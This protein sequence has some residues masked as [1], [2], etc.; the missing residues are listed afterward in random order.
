MIF[1]FLSCVLPLALAYGPDGANGSIEAG[2]AEGPQGLDE[3]LHDLDAGNARVAAEALEEL[4]EVGGPAVRRALEELMDDQAEP[5][6][7]RRWRARLVAR[8]GEGENV[9]AALK[10]LDD[11]DPAVRRELVAFLSRPGLEEQLGERIAALARLAV[12]DPSL[13]VRTRAIGGLAELDEVSSHRALNGLL[14]HLPGPERL[15]AARGLAGAWRARPFVLER[16]RA[17]FTP[18]DDGGNDGAGQRTPDDVLAVLLPAYGRLLAEQ[19]SGGETAADRV[20]LVLGLRHPDPTVRV[21]AGL[22]FDQLIRRLRSLADLDRARRILGAMDAE[23]FDRRV[24]LYEQC[25]M[26]LRGRPDTARARHTAIE[27]G[28]LCGDSGT[29]EERDWRVSANYLEALSLFAAGDCESAA[30][31]LARAGRLLDGLLA[32]RPDERRPELVPK[33]DD[34][35]HLSARVAL[36]QAVTLEAARAVVTD[37]ETAAPLAPALELLRNA[38]ELELQAQLFAQENGLA[39]LN[40]LDLLLDDDLSPLTVLLS[41]PGL[42]AWT[43]EER[44][45]ICTLV[46]RGIRSVAPE[47]MPGFEPFDDPDARAPELLDLSRQTLLAEFKKARVGELQSELAK[48]WEATLDVDGQELGGEQRNRL[49]MVGRRLQI[50]REQELS[51]F[52]FPST[53]ALRLSALM[54]DE[55]A[56]P[57]EARE[58]VLRMRADLDRTGHLQSSYQGLELAAQIDISVGASYMDEGAPR[59]AEVE[60]EKAV[61]RLEEYEQLAIERG[62]PASI[63]GRIRLRRSTALVSLAVNANV[64][65]RD[66][67]RALGFFERAYALRQDDFMKVLLACYRARSNEDEAARRILRDVPPA[68]DLYYNLACTYALLGESAKAILY[69]QREFEENHVGDASLAKQQQWARQDPDLESLRDDARFVA[70]T[71]G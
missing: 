29:P 52:R 26:S 64:K 1:R 59:R 53:L 42:Q 56:R 18:L 37:V 47:E 21:A 10:E 24:L 46:A 33:V 5:T 35:L 12:E 2:G 51:E 66:P 34:W 49:L 25:L 22:G 71:G 62:F 6:L 69:L 3:R 48:L 4:A 65:L 9:P 31:P 50:T 8:A 70:I 67:E 40:D 54:R 58:L 20:P 30:L 38:H 68:P 16:V 39:V 36:F 61:E 45:A 28:E 57:R 15:L 19:P 23:G 32:E 14:D 60:L 7:G 41:T 44:V 11:P 17:G 27:L 43:P 63:V 13:A 55:G